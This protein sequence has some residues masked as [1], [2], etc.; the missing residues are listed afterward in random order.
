MSYQDLRFETEETSTRVGLAQR[1][2]DG[3]V[4]VY[5]QALQ[6]FGLY[7]MWKDAT[8]RGIT[9]SVGQEVADRCAADGFHRVH[10][11]VPATEIPKMTDAVYDEIAAVAPEFLE[12][13]MAGAFPDVKNFYYEPKPNVRFHIPFDLARGFKKEFD[14]FAKDYGQGKISAHGPHRDS[15]LDCARERVTAT[16]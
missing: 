9:K 1:I 10:E 3:E 11:W 12:R 8:L 13:F 16:R 2:I 5:R 15:W 7:D 6:A 4:F 14:E